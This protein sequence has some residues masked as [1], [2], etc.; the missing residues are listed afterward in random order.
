M[1]VSPL[2]P[3]V[4]AQGLSLRERARAR[5]GRAEL[6]LFR[7]AAE[8]FATEL[9]LSEE[10]I[11]LSLHPVHPVPGR[12]ASRLGVVNVRET[13]LPLYTPAAVLGMQAPEAPAMAIV[14]PTS[15]GSVAIAVD[16]V[17]DVF[18]ADLAELRDAP[19]QS[20]TVGAVLGALHHEGR[21]VAIVDAD[22]LIMAC[23]GE[24]AGTATQERHPGMTGARQTRALKLET[25]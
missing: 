4:A 11:E 2:L 20:R 19:G 7:V 13:L 3:P 1:T 21:L 10:A 17:E 5:E 6:L 14:F 25:T 8:Y 12:L 18:S 22:A 16:E 23:R 9:T 15:S 24:I